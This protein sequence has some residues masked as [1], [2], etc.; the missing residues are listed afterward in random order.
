MPKEITPETHFNYKIVLPQKGK[1]IIFRLNHCEGVEV[2]SSE[3]ITLKFN[4]GRFEYL[5]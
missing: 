2:I 3:K 5:P 1:D 4:D